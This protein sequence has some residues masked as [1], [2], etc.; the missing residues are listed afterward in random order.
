MGIGVASGVMNGEQTTVV[1]QFFGAP[2]PAP[3]ET[4]APIV[5]RALELVSTPAEAALVPATQEVAGASSPHIA[6][7]IERAEELELVE[8]DT[9]TPPAPT[10]TPHASTHIEN[11]PRMSL[12]TSVLDNLRAYSVALL[13]V[14]LL[15]IA[16][17]YVVHHYFYNTHISAVAFGSTAL[18]IIIITLLYN[19]VTTDTFAIVPTDIQNASTSAVSGTLNI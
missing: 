10:H 17:L 9:E 18:S 12:F 15:G 14:L 4:P 3:Q 1:V 19:L 2:A 16:S 6:Q 11:T 13:L 5:A 7:N 8:K